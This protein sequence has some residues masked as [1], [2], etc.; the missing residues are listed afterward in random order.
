MIIIK[1]IS[2]LNPAA[3][4]GKALTLAECRPEGSD[5]YIT[6][7]VG[8]A[9][10]FAYEQ[11]LADKD[12]SFVVC[13]GDGTLNE[14]INGVMKAGTNATTQISMV[15]T[16]SGNDFIRNL[17]E[18][19]RKIKIDLMR[20]NNRYAVNVINTGFDSKVV[21]KMHKYKGI[22]LVSGSLSYILAVAEVFF[23]RMG[24]RYDVRMTKA[25]GEDEHFNGEYLSVVVA[26]GSYYGG[27]FKAAPLALLSDGLLD[28][29]MIKKISRL[30]FIKLIVDYRNGT[31]LDPDT[32]LLIGKFAKHLIYRQCTK[33][34][35]KGMTE[36]AADGEI[37]HASEI[38]ITVVPEMINF[39]S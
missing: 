26:N 36:L 29:I 25:N 32:G 4:K 8:D 15:P 9:E 17:S 19:G 18:K 27:G 22:P 35:I 33:I 11:S 7:G 12:I 34:A 16:G 21:I 20:Y 30:A 23:R 13:G 6:K 24:E 10:K 37:E 31:H 1:T 28:V 5:S 38:E 39:S 14:V 2:I 3:G